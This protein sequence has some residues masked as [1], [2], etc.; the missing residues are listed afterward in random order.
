MHYV[1]GTYFT[2]QTLYNKQFEI[3]IK[4]TLFRHAEGHSD[5]IVKEPYAD[6]PSKI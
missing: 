3:Y 2:Y 6:A 5:M 4:K 1:A